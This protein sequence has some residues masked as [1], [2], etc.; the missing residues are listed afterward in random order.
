MA[1]SAE[2]LITRR[3]A[4]LRA[5]VQVLIDGASQ[6]ERDHAHR[7]DAVRPEH[8]ASAI[9][10][11]HYVWLRGR[12]IR[13]L[14]AELADL[15]LSSLGRLE[16]RVMPTLRSLAGALDLM[17][18]SDTGP[19][20][21][22][23]E[24]ALGPALLDRNADNLLGH[25]PAD[26]VSRIMVTFPSEAA[27]DRDLVG[28][29][30]A[31]GMDIARINAAHDTPEDWAA[32]IA[33]LRATDPRYEGAATGRPEGDDGFR[34]APDRCLVAMDLAGPKLRTGP[35]APGPE[36]VRVRPQRDESG[37]VVEPATVVL[38]ASPSGENSRHRAHL[39]VDADWLAALEVDERIGFVDARG[40]EREL[41]VTAVDDARAVTEMTQTAYFATGT[42]LSG[43][44]DAAV[45]ALPATESHHFVRKGEQIWLT[46][47][48]DAHGP[49]EGG[50]HRIG[51]TLPQVFEDATAGQEVWFDDGKV[52]GTIAAVRDDRIEI[53]VTSAGVD[54][55]K[56][57]AEK[58]INLPDTQLDTPALTDEDLEVLPFVVEH[59]DIVNYS[60]VRDRGDVADLF[61]RVTE[62]GRDDL[63]VVLKIETVQAFR[64]LPQILLEAMRWRDVGVMIARGDLAVEAGFERLAEVQEEIMWLCEAAHVPVIWATQVLESLAKRGMPSRAE[65]TDAAMSERAECVMLNK[66]PFIV[67]AIRF[68]HDVLERMQ[69]HQSKKRTLLRRLDSWG[70]D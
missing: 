37:H 21:R 44:S 46:R 51:C 31:A 41:V 60:F 45:G 27:T 32:M 35:I 11:V 5:L 2:P 28:Q 10:L 8:R 24:M 4:R 18:G 68:L 66:G 14:Q 16:S 54:G 22:G 26:R 7:I 33:N 12:D 69:D 43:M 42:V 59:A 52:G 64:N 40:S 38:E 55:V 23:G 25:Q 48:L 36:V 17:I 1:E 70:L 53:D 63:D 56:L 65:V 15:G 13:E 61:R 20:L 67:E 3:A 30:V 39:P 50:P 49:V 57:R 58:G 29:M 6:A 62:L 9:N 47:S 19:A 34:P